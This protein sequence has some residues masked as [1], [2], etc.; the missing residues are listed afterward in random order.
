[1]KEVKRKER[2]DVLSPSWV[3]GEGAWVTMAH[4]VQKGSDRDRKMWMRLLNSLLDIGRVRP[5]VLWRGGAI[6]GRP[7]VAYGTPS[8]LS[9]V[10]FQVALLATRQDA[11]VVCS[12]CGTGYTPLQRAPKAGQ[13]NFC[14]QCRAGG[15][16]AMLSQRDKRA[17]LREEKGL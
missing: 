12:Y 6:D 7:S 10:A 3:S 4:F 11:F 8:L 9:Y 5:I 14:S 13:R 15:V 17:R 1:M 2:Y 16:P